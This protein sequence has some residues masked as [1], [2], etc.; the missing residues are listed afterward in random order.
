[1]PESTRKLVVGLCALTVL[2]AAFGRRISRA[3]IARARAEASRLASQRDSL[4]AV[5]RERDRRQA[6]LTAQREAHEAAALRLRDSVTA[7]E[8]RRAA[9]Q[10]AVRELRTTGALQSRLRTAF[11]ELGP[12]GWGVT[13]LP[14]DGGDSL[15]LE[16]L[17]VPAWFSETF[18]IDHANAES[19]RAQKDQL[20]VADSLRLVVTALQD[21]VTQLVAAS[22]AAYAGGYQ[23]ASDAYRELS[24]R[25]VA[26]LRKPRFGRGPAV[27]LLGAV[28]AGLL[29]GGVIR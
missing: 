1:M 10:F 26:E 5:V 24:E 15:G 27:G 21:S 4:L 18:L 13:T 9:E 12:V 2:W 6:A 17:L 23:A 19:W 7:L 16:Y 8:R 20:L 22:A 29:I 14:F 25:H 3:A 28:A 11:P